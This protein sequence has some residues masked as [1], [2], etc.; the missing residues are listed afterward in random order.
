MG[1]STSEIEALP[2]GRGRSEMVHRDDLELGWSE[3]HQLNVVPLGKLLK[4][5]D[6][7]CAVG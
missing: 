4:Q 1:L 6:R 5:L 2:G 3:R 7:L